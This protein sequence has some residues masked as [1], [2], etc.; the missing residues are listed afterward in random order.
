[1]NERK[2]EKVRERKREREK[3]RVLR[4]INGSFIIKY[5]FKYSCIDI[6]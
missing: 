1:M 6:R 5:Y 3:K 2:K 4:I